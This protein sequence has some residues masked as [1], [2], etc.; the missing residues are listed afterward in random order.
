MHADELEIDSALVGRLLAA[1]F[2]EWASLP[3]EPV[4]F[5]GTDNA[6]YRLGNDMAVRLPRR[7]KNVGQLEKERRWL[8]RLAPL[9]PLAIPVPIA[10]GTPG[11]GYP[12]TWSVYR[13]LEGETA[14]VAH[15]GELG[16]AAVEL[17]RFVAALQHVDPTDGPPPGE[18]NAF[19][20][21][22][23]ATRDKATR[24]AIAS[25][26]GS[27]D[28][29]AVTAAWEEALRAPA[30][31]RSPVWIHGDLDARNLLVDRGRLS[32]VIDFGCLG[33]G[34]PACDVMVVWKVLSADTR[35]TFRAALSVDDATWSRS[36]GWALSQALMALSYYT[37]E[38][39]PQLVSE[40]RRWLMEVLAEP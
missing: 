38:T 35:K 39:N 28:N 13:W 36:R 24:S 17:A 2:P 27:V 11:A 40:A 21:V 6:I 25:V 16:H 15:I 37:A 1:Q 20:G 26:G 34:D 32:G 31:E 3:L 33:V 9:L 12:F 18:H 4:P 5:F 19:R 7:Q 23:L 14:T 8:P 10:A 30:W 29:A 22:P